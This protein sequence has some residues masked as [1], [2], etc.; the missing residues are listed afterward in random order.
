[1]AIVHANGRQRAGA[2]AGAMLVQLA[3]GYVLIVGLATSWEGRREQ[4]LESFDVATPPPP[5]ERPVPAV[6]HRRKEGAAAP[7]N[8]R[9]TPSEVVAPIPTVPLPAPIPAAPI[10]GAG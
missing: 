6:A 4:V 7:R 2:A 1:M 3:L 9:A 5:L 8:L 10:A